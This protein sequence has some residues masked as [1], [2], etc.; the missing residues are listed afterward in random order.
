VGKFVTTMS[1]A[2]HLFSRGNPDAQIQVRVV[3]IVTEMFS[4]TRQT[5]PHRT[6]FHIAGAHCFLSTNSPEVLRTT[7]RWRRASSAND[8]NSFEM[9]ILVDAIASGSTEPSPH[10]RGLRHLVFVFLPDRCF[11]CYD[12][13]RKRVHGVISPALAG[14]ATFW[15]SLLL[16]MTIG[17]L[18]ATIGV[19]PLHCACLDRDGS[20]VL[21]AGVSGA[22]K[23]TLAAALAQRGFPLVSDDWTYMAGQGASLIAR[24]LFAPIK[25]LPNSAQFF[26]CLGELSPRKTLNGELAYEFEPGATLGCAV[27]D[28]SHPRWL[29]FLERTAF[30]GC[31]FVPSRP[32][33]VRDFFEHNAER[34][35]DELRAASF[36][37][38]QI[39][40][41][42]SRCPAWILQTSKTPQQTAEAIDGFLREERYATA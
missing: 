29:F 31:Q 2:C 12:L 4:Y 20:G 5:L 25:L 22:G 40:R 19:V 13:L 17:I 7:L 18:G 28:V 34:L 30:G 39:I 36:D 15:D 1:R 9:E 16:P 41:Q 11:F 23:S 6:D 24:G 14:D 21:I 26:P 27:K 32:E 8:G 10:F 42:L 3:S 37:R 38:S 33:Y 35:P